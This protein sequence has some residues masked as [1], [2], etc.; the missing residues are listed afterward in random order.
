MQ[1][2]TTIVYTAKAQMILDEANVERVQMCRAVGT[3]P[4]WTE[5]RIVEEDVERR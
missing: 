1:M 5:H 4:A 2:H 3:L